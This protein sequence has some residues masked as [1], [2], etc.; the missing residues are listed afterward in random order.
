MHLAY[1]IGSCHNEEGRKRR[2]RDDNNNSIYDLC[3][4]ADTVQMD[5][6]TEKFQTGKSTDEKPRQPEHWEK[7]WFDLCKFPR[8]HYVLLLAVSLRMDICAH[9][10][11]QDQQ[12]RV[13]L[14]VARKLTHDLINTIHPL[15]ENWS[16]LLVRKILGGWM[17]KLKLIKQ[18]R[19]ASMHYC[20]RW[21]KWWCPT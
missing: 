8:R 19:T 13:E 11:W 4:V 20:A 21:R 1:S 9:L 18:I 6:Q 7:T 3:K 16:T 2:E 5:F 17:G 12:V 14:E 10:V 15:Q